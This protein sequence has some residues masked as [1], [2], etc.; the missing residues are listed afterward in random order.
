[1]IG[2]VPLR[3]YR[4]NT[5]HRI[6]IWNWDDDDEFCAGKGDLNVPDTKRFSDKIAKEHR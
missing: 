1:M 6:A 3:S 4:Y 5:T 2:L